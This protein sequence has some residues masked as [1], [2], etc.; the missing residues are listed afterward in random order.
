MEGK[1]RQWC[2]HAYLE[3]SLLV[4]HDI[5]AQTGDESPQEVQEHCRLP[6]IYV[7]F[8]SRIDGR[9]KRK[10]RARSIHRSFQACMM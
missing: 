1:K 7:L 3:Y 10:G 6:V 4:G 5:L 9:E 8:V 2:M